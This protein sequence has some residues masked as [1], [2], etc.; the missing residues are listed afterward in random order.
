MLGE[1]SMEKK[2]AKNKQETYSPIF[3]QDGGQGRDNKQKLEDWYKELQDNNKDRA[4]LR[5]AVS[6]IQATVNESAWRLS[7]L[8]PD[9]NTIPE[10]PATL[11]AILAHVKKDNARWTGKAFP[12]EL[13]TP[14][15]GKSENPIMTE[16]RFG[17]LI[18]CRN[19]DEFF[20]AMRRAVQMN[21]DGAHIPSLADGIV[22]WGLEHAVK[23]SGNGRQKWAE[24]KLS[25]LKSRHSSVHGFVFEWSRYYFTQVLQN[26]NQ[27]SPKQKKKE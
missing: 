3:F 25:R 9:W 22:L 23:E 17:K 15:Q 24:E 13:A 26:E 10:I 7:E 20:T 2:E 21:G 8:L 6:P 18:T 4:Y 12:E 1:K 27:G 5:R 16:S 11:A 14:A 19:W